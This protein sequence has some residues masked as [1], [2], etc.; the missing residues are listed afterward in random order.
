MCFYTFEKQ[1][2]EEV[3]KLTS[4]QREEMTESLVLDLNNPENWHQ[5]TR[6]PQSKYFDDPN[7]TLRRLDLP[8]QQLKDLMQRRCGVKVAHVLISHISDS[9]YHTV[10][11]LFTMQSA[12]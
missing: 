12:I 11:F 8:S 7:G 3:K 1:R 4:A 6:R 9:N 2:K 5:H 10:V